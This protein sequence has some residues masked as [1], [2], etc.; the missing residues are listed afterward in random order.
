MEIKERNEEG[1]GRGSKNL[2]TD[3]VMPKSS[4]RGE[5]ICTT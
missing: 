1:M 4:S 2:G 3:E 5:F